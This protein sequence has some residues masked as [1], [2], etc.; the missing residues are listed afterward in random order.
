MPLGDRERESKVAGEGGGVARTL[1][2]LRRKGDEKTQGQ[3]EFFGRG[4]SLYKETT[5]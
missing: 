5:E 3:C 2:A 4:R 1:R